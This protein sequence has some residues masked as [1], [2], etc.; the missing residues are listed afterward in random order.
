MELFRRDPLNCS[1]QDIVAIVAAF[2]ERRKQFNLG[3]L[4]AGKVKI[5]PK[6]AETLKA[7]SGLK[8]LD[9]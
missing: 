4:S 1:K 2:R 7:V 9:L 3:N 8:D 5:T 6:Q